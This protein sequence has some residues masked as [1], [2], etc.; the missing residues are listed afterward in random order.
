MDVG[1]F[2]YP[3][4]EWGKGAH[5]GY[6]TRQDNGFATIFLKEGVCAVQI[7]FFQETYFAAKS[8]WPDIMTNPII[9]C[10]SQ[11]CGCTEQNP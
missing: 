11:D 9:Y 2:A 6:E 8:A 7:F 5:N 3:G 10:I 1:H 4:D